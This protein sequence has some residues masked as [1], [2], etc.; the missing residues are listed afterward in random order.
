MAL[1]SYYFSI[2]ATIPNLEMTIFLIDGN[3]EVDEMILPR[4][5][6]GHKCVWEL[7]VPIE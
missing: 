2:L 5:T 6:N 1:S 3:Y 4:R 7:E